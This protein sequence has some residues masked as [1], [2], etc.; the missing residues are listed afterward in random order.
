MEAK[1][2]THSQPFLPVEHHHTL[3]CSLPCSQIPAD[4]YKAPFPCH[5]LTAIPKKV[6]THFFH[7]HFSQ[8][9]DSM[10]ILFC[11]A[12]APHCPLFFSLPSF[13]PN[14]APPHFFM[15][16]E[17]TPHCLF[18]LSPAP[19][20]HTTTH[21]S[22][23]AEQ[24]SLYFSP[25]STSQLTTLLASSSHMS[26]VHVHHLHL[27]FFQSLPRIQNLLMHVIPLDSSS[28]K[29]PVH[30]S[31]FRMRVGLRVLQEERGRRCTVRACSSR[32]GRRLQRQLWA[33]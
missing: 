2:S 11:P 8:P 32:R 5:L 22:L 27:L 26:F 25:H 29:L 19:S 17:S 9:N 31:N 15:P 28:P 33:H 13:L 18:L 23:P 21:F 7:A 6:T 10:P 20:H 16:A 14:T 24:L 3:H 12:E 1:L 4:T 30:P